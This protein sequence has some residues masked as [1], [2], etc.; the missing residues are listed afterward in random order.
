MNFRSTHQHNELLAQYSVTTPVAQT[1]TFKAE[2]QDVQAIRQRLQEFRQLY[3]PGN[4]KFSF[5]G[6]DLYI[7]TDE[8]HAYDDLSPQ[9]TQINGWKTYKPLWEGIINESISNQR[10]TRLDI[11]R[12]ETSG[13]LGWSAITVR[14]RAKNKGKDFYNSQHLT[15]IWHKVDGKWKIV[16]EHAFS[17]VIENGKEALP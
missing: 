10:I 12:I 3:S 11:D 7:D 14:F 15:H 13:D 17:P 6:Y 8:L 16:H 2:N 9:N 4:R 5:D 1:E